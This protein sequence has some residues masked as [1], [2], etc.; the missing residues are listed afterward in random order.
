MLP[1]QRA[2]LDNC[3]GGGCFSTLD[4]KG[5][6][7]NVRVSERTRRK[8]G[9]V[10]RKGLF[11]YNRLTFGVT[12]GPFAFQYIIDC[13]L[14]GLEGTDGFLDDI[15]VRG[16]HWTCTWQRTLTALR[17]LIQAGF[18][19]NLRKCKFLV[20]QFMLLGHRLTSNYMQL[21]DKCIVGW[22]DVGVPHTVAELQT[23]LGRLAWAAPFIPDYKRHVSP[24]EA[25]LAATT[26]F[27]WTQECTDAL[28]VM[29]RHVFSRLRLRLP[30]FSAPFR[31]HPDFD[32]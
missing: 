12:D 8:M 15:T 3:A 2:I 18:V 9:V 26:S 13:L 7:N 24:L 16:E 10:T 17:K 19:V 4:L 29:L 28:N 11:W 20:E 32:D 23:L 6:F 27:E 25:L 30:D 22:A 31:L 14:R 5:A 21:G 1:D